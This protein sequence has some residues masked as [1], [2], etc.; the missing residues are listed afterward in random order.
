VTD[1]GDSALSL[2]ASEGHREVVSVL[3][4][5]GATTEEANDIGDTP[6]IKA[7]CHGHA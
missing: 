3:L 6:L 4:Q 5:A 7:A 1:F 2:A